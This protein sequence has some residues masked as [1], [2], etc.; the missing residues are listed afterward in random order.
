VVVLPGILFAVVLGISPET[1]ASALV[2]KLGSERFA[3][4]EDAARRLAEIGVDALPVLRSAST[5]E[6]DPELRSRAILLID[7]IER[8]ALLRPTLVTVAPGNLD[9]IA[10]SLNRQLSG[11]ALTTIQSVGSRRLHLAEAAQLSFWSAIDAITE[12]DGSQARPVLDRFSWQAHAA[13]IVRFERGGA[14]VPTSDDGPFRFRLARAEYGRQRVFESDPEIPGEQQQARQVHLKLALRIWAEP[15]LGI[16]PRGRVHITRAIDDCGQVYAVNEP[17]GSQDLPEDSLLV[18]ESCQRAANL[19]ELPISL[20]VPP[21]QAQRLVRFEGRT[22][23]FVS[24]RGH[25]RIELPL[26]A[27]ERGTIVSQSQS[28]EITAVRRQREDGEDAASTEIDLTWR[29][30]FPIA[31]REPEDLSA[32]VEVLDAQ[33][34]LLFAQLT[35]IEESGQVRRLTLLVTSSPSEGVPDKIRLYNRVFAVANGNFAFADVPLP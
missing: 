19:V 2:Q 16:Q 3:A 26:R 27:G 32:L 15:R 31:E 35:A 28:V 18:S 9:T 1:D 4:R 33:A 5:T 8:Q 7:R 24:S 21:I 13:A 10:S 30:A 29:D 25:E 11:N 20:S 12:A 6:P 23:L 34:R 22:G 14:P 17:A